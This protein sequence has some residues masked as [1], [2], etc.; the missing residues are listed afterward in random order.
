[1]ND[2][3][4]R[5]RIAEMYAEG[6]TDLSW[7]YLSFVG[8]DG[9][10]GAV[11]LEAWHLADAITRSHELGLNPGGEVMTVGPLDEAHMDEHVAPV[12]RYRLLSRDEVDSH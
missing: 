12:M 5:E 8:E 6:G 2:N 4:V 11:Y 9:F 7:W 1:M 3:R 10:R